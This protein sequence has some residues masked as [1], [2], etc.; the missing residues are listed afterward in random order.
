MRDGVSGTGVGAVR[1]GRRNQTG[2]TFLK[3]EPAELAERWDG[4]CERK[5][6]IKDGS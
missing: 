5:R 3:V 6:R 1:V 4:G 2:D